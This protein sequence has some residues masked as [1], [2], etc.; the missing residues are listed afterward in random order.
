MRRSGA[1]LSVA[2]GLLAAATLFSLLSGPSRSFAAEEPTILTIAGENVSVNRPVF[3]AFNDAFFAF[4]D[5]AFTNGHS[6]TA[7]DLRALPQVEI[8][9]AAE[10]WT[11][12]ITAKGPRLSDVLKKAGVADGATVGLVALD[13][14]AVTLDPVERKTRDWVLA[15]EAD[16]EPLGI[17][18]R[19]PA[20]LMY[21]SGEAPISSDD[22]ALWVW[23][24]YLITVD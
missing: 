2:T 4:S 19:G 6:L 11:K 13:G 17:G 22:E 1:T 15:I 3:E 5:N 7:S 21:E 9:A 12:K 23:S 18:G 10:G 16:G 24:V 20:W 8:T 14:Y